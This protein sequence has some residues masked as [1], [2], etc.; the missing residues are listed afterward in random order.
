MLYM[1]ALEHQD[2]LRRPGHWPTQDPKGQWAVNP[3]TTGSV[4]PVT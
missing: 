2:V 1:K 3:A 4:T